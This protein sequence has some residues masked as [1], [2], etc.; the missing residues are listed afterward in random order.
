[1]FDNKILYHDEHKRHRMHHV[2]VISRNEC[3]ESL[4]KNKLSVNEINAPERQTD[5]LY[6]QYEKQS[7]NKKIT[8]G[9]M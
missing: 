3:V 8:I 5:K 6:T 4:R 1:M 2:I 7:K 9:K